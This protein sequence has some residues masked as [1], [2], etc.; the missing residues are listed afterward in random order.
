MSI[1]FIVEKV[2]LSKKESFTEGEI[3]NDSRLKLFQ[4]RKTIINSVISS[5]ISNGII[6]IKDYSHYTINKKKANRWKKE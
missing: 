1:K 6:E 3:I 2:I 4:Y 5:F